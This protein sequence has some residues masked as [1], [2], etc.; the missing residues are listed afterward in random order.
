MSFLR[1]HVEFKMLNSIFY[2]H[3]RFR[4]AFSP[5]FPCH[6]M[7]HRF[8]PNK[9]CVT[10]PNTTQPQPRSSSSLSS[11]LD[12]SGL[13][14][15][16]S[17]RTTLNVLKTKN[18]ITSYSTHVTL[19]SLSPAGNTEKLFQPEFL[20]LTLVVSLFLFALKFCSHADFKAPSLLHHPA[21]DGAMFRTKVWYC[22]SARTSLE[23]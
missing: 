13:Q 7:G 9:N 15:T 22:S 5:L 6:P 3:R 16:D 18:I 8:R 21:F 14:Y 4:T 2:N 1:Q 11:A 19:L 20:N 12:C 23:L 17:A 10:L